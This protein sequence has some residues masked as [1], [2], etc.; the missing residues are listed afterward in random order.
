MRGQNLL[1]TALLGN[2]VFA[3]FRSFQQRSPVLG[4]SDCDDDDDDDDG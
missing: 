1:A 3:V 4:C 2:P